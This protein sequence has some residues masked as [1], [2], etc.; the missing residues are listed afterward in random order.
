MTVVFFTYTQA[1]PPPPLLA[2]MMVKRQ[3]KEGE[4]ER[5]KETGDIHRKAKQASKQATGKGELIT[6]VFCPAKGIGIQCILY[7]TATID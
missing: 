7:T 2:M 1:V 5:E 3:K 6:A 4:R